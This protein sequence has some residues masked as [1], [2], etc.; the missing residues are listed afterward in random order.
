MAKARNTRDVGLQSRDEAPFPASDPFEQRIRQ[1]RALAPDDVENTPNEQSIRRAR[2]LLKRIRLMT[3]STQNTAHLAHPFVT[4]IGDGIIQMEWKHGERY[5][6]AEVPPKGPFSVWHEN[7]SGEGE[8]HP[9][10]VEEMT[11]LFVL[12]WQS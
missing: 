6:E 9:R 3:R 12:F 4:L 8:A 2:G 5:M 10:D 11:E 1:L 7:P